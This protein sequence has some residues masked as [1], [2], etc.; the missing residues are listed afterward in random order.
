ME[1]TFRHSDG[2]KYG[3]NSIHDG[4]KIE[5]N[6]LSPKLL[7][8]IV[9]SLQEKKF[10]IELML[11]NREAVAIA[12]CLLAA[13]NREFRISAVEKRHTNSHK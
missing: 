5:A 10:R 2:R 9:S 4:L 12:Q 13:T 3:P 7:Y 11:S 8:L 1:Y 6:A